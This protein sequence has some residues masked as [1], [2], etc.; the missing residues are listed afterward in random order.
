MTDKKVARA[1]LSLL[2]LANDLNN[3]SKACK[4]TGY[5]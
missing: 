5:S 4:I 3:V 2:Q 1:K